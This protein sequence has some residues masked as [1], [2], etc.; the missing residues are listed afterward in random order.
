MAQEAVQESIVSF[1]DLIKKAGDLQMMPQTARK[2]IELVSNESSTA[3][4]L[5]QVIEK[6]ANITTRILKIANSAF[7]GLRREVT[8][9]QHAIV[10]L[11]YKSVR[12]LVVA[13]SSKAMHKRFGITEQLMWDHSVGTAIFGRMIAKGKAT[14]VGEL[15]FVGGLLHNLGKAIMNNE[16]P[17]AYMEVMKRVYNEGVT[18]IEAEQGIFSY[19]YPEVGFRVIEKW[20]LPESITKIIRYHRLSMMKPEKQEE[21]LKDL[22]QDVKLGVACVEMAVEMCRFL[23]IGYK[24]PNKEVKLASLKSAELLGLD[25]QKITELLA[26]CETAYQEEKAIFE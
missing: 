25:E 12:S 15:A 16:S 14:A 22:D 19:T 18:Y 9:V 13:S 23:G 4:D 2:V 24:G 20:G 8:T 5:A 21:G 1:D 17:K 26:S 6:D 7:Y 10:I 11:G 3:Q